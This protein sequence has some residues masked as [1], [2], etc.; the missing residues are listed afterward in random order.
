M[1]IKYELYLGLLVLA[2]S[3]L[4]CVESVH[5]GAMEVELGPRLLTRVH[6]VV[7]LRPTSSHVSIS[8]P[9]LLKH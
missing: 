1:S 2:L 6:F 9:N 8:Y 5:A 4:G 3:N 7:A